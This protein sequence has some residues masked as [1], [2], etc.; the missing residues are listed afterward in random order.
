V[1]NSVLISSFVVD[2]DIDDSSEGLKH[3]VKFFLHANGN[4]AARFPYD[5]VGHLNVQ[6]LKAS[7]YFLKP[8]SDTL[9]SLKFKSD[10]PGS[11]VLTRFL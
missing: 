2:V 1:L 10:N 4:I 7:A 3:R 11:L 8:D 9:V 5:Q 6:L